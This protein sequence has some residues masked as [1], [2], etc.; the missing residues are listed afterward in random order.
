MQGCII[1][2][3]AA[4]PYGTLIKCCAD[5]QAAAGSAQLSNSNTAVNCQLRTWNVTFLISTQQRSTYHHRQPSSM[6]LT[7]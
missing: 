7:R 2:W 1:S 3:V 6:A 5:A 4:V